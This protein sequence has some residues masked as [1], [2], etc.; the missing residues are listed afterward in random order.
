MGSGM[1]PDGGWSPERSKCDEKLGIFSS[2]SLLQRGKR[3]EMELIIDRASVMK[4]F[5]ELPGW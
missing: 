5:G 1:A 2:I 3:L 4:A